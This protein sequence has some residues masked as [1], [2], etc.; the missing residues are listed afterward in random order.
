MEAVPAN[1]LG[2]VRSQASQVCVIGVDEGQFVSIFSDAALIQ[3]LLIS[4]IVSLKK[5]IKLKLHNFL[6]YIVSR[7]RG[8]L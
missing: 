2:D 7:H 3:M 8:V 5:N 4:D 1:R 6:F